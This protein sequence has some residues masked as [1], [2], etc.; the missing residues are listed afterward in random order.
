MLQ[1]LL[2][3]QSTQ[4]GR[5]LTASEIYSRVIGSTVTITTNRGQGSGFYVAPHVIATN[6]HVIEGVTSATSRIV[7]TG[8]EINVLGYLA[9]NKDADLILLQVGGTAQPPLRFANVNLSIGE[10]IYVIGA[11]RG[12]EGTITR[13]IVSSVR[14]EDDLTLVQIDAAISPGSSGSPVVNQRAE[15]IGVAKGTFASGQS[16]NFA[17]CRTHLQ[18]LMRQMSDRPLPLSALF[19]LPSIT[20]VNLTGSTVSTILMSPTTDDSW[21]SDRLANRPVIRNGESVTL[22]LPYPLHITN[23]YDIRLTDLNRNNYTRMDVL[24]QAN[25]RIVF[26]QADL[27]RR[28]TQPAPSPPRANPIP[29]PRATQPPPSQPPRTTPPP[30]V[31]QPPSLRIWEIFSIG[32]GYNNNGHFFTGSIVR[33]HN[34]FFNIGILGIETNKNTLFDIGF[35]V[36]LVTD[37]HANWVLKT[38]I[39]WTYNTSANPNLGSFSSIDFRVDFLFPLLKIYV[40]TGTDNIFSL[41]VNV[42]IFGAVNLRK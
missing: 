15:V 32:Y 34:R 41:G 24:V 19:A 29:P 40:K 5:A 35:G 13:G 18:A 9:V 20:I 16:L 6:F 7:G 11:P 37:Y 31:S 8:R 33:Y 22:E 23:R 39:N 36:P 3:Q 38:S 27:D 30:R 2:L 28:T 14:N 26:I 4:Q 1:H 12:L 25:S 42:N 10:D 21:G 17:I